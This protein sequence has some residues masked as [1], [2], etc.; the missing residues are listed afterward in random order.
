MTS[1]IFDQNKINGR[2]ITNYV[3]NIHKYLEF[4]LTKEENNNIS[5]LELSI[6]RNNNYLHLGI[7]RKL[8][9]TDTTSHIQPSIRT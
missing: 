7:N 4:K 5:Y 9:Q 2:L 8:T 6:Q 1:I 3:N